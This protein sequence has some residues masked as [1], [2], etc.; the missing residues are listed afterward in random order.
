MANLL[1]IDLPFAATPRR[2]PAN[3]FPG[4]GTGNYRPGKRTRGD[5]MYIGGG[6]LA[7]IIVII[8]LV[9]LL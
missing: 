4:S 2:A 8:L 6:A 7:L 3:G 1:R 5:A 9:W